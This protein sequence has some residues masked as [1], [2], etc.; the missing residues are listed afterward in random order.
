MERRDLREMHGEVE[1][2]KDG[3][4]EG[5]RS[6]RQRHKRINRWSDDWIEVQME[7]FT[8]RER[9]T[10]GL[11]NNGTVVQRY[12]GLK[13]RGIGKSNGETD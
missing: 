6:R 1:G 13:R 12:G 10:E 7:G 8:K 11:M 2:A 3:E 5:L 4:T 9:D